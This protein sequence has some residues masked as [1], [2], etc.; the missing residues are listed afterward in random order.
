MLIKYTT[1]MV[2]KDFGLTA[3]VVT[4]ILAQY[5]A[6]PKSA[7]TALDERQLSLIFEHLTQNNQVESIESMCADVYHEP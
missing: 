1:S 7:S 4:E 6:A 3:K 5:G 2:A